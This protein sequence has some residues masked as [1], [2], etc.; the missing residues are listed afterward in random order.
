MK[1]VFLYVLMAFFSLHTMA[2]VDKQPRSAEERADK[3]TKAMQKRLNLTSSQTDQARAINLERAKQADVLKADVSQ[4][5]KDNAMDKDSKMAFKE[6]ATTI[7]NDHK[8]KFGEILNGE[9]K[10]KYDKMIADNKA[11]LQKK[12]AKKMNKKGKTKGT[13]TKDNGSLM[14]DDGVDMDDEDM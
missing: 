10:V 12:R 3:M 5:R 7:Q 4:K 2:Q 8:A 1:K 14:D 6:R 9:Q 13:G 11:R